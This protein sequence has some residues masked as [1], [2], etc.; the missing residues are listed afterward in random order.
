[1]YFYSVVIVGKHP[2]EDRMVCS[3]PDKEQAW[4][5]FINAVEA[6]GGGRQRVE[7]R[8]HLPCSAIMT[9]ICHS[10]ERPWRRKRR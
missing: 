10:G 4:I 6:K 2:D 1:M 5:D 3:V 8:E 7:L 9:V